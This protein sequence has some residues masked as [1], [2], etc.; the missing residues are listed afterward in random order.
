MHRRTLSKKSSSSSSTSFFP[1]PRSDAITGTTLRVLAP[2]ISGFARAQS[3]LFPMGRFTRSPESSLGKLK[4]GR[5]VG[6]AGLE[7]EESREGT[8]GLSHESS[9]E[10]E[11]RLAKSVF[12][13][14]YEPVAPTEEDLREVARL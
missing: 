11:S 4:K 1:S 14:V 2:V 10:F 3:Q 13:A 12:G 8:E 6:D 7:R 9:K 5:K